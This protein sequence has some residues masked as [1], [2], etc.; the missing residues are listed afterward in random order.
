MNRE[1]T[2]ICN[3]YAVA[4]DI[5]VMT[6]AER[7]A[8]L[9]VI[10]LQNRFGRLTIEQIT[11]LLGSDFNE[12]WPALELVLHQENGLYYIPWLD[13]LQVSKPKSIPLTKKEIQGYVH[14]FSNL[15]TCAL[16]PPPWC[17]VYGVFVFHPTSKRERLIY[18]GSSGNVKKRVMA[19]THPYRLAY[20]RFN[21]LYVYTKTLETD[22]YIEVEKSLI[23][24]FKPILNRTYKNG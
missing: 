2:F 18:I 11:A 21:N 10:L 16:G 24:H 1:T 13:E 23:R 17:G 19:A 12:C 15:S 7:G 5:M 20:D 14:E 6:K 9:D 22:N 8:Y 4:S 3:H